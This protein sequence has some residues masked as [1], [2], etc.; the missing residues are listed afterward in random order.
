MYCM[1]SLR[2]GSSGGAMLRHYS[3]DVRAPR[4]FDRGLEKMYFLPP[5]RSEP[6]SNRLCFRPNPRVN[7]RPGDGEE[8]VKLPLFR[9]RGL[10][11]TDQIHIIASLAFP[12]ADPPR[13][14]SL[15]Q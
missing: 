6:D 3:D 15:L 14:A 4:D 7:L 9:P 10:A 12:Q 5:R 11:R 8:G 1:R 2:Y 13:M